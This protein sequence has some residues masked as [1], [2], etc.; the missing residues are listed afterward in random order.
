MRDQPGDR[1]RGDAEH[2][3]AC[4]APPTRR[5]PGQRRGRGGDCVTDGHAGVAVGRQRPAGVEAE[6]AHPQQAGADQVSTRLCGCIGSCVALALAEH[7]GSDQAG[8]PALMCTTVPPAKS[9]TPSL[10]PASRPA[11]RPSGPPAVDDERPQRMNTSIAENLHALGE[12]AGDQRGRDDGEHQ[13]KHHVHRLGNRRRQVA[14]GTAAL[15]VEQALEAKTR[16]AAE[17]RRVRGEG[18]AVAEEHPQHGDQRRRS[19]GSASWWTA[20]SSC[21]PCRRRTAPG[22]AAS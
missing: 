5:H 2:A 10:T 1:A 22:P 15:R 4:R 11:A 6:P 18:Q 9:S 8:T 7:E 12:G 21:G 16:R 19:R 20:R 14:H 3:W 17:P 13:L